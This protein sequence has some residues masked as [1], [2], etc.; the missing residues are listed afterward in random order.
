M[1]G[2][3]ALRNDHAL[4]ETCKPIVATLPVPSPFT[5][6]DM[7][8][9]FGLQREQAR[10]IEL[11][12]ARLGGTA[13]CGLYVVTDDVDYVVH[14]TDTSPFHSLHIVMHEVGHWLLG[15][16]DAALA[17]EAAPA[18]ACA[19][20]QPADPDLG[21]AATTLPEPAKLVTLLRQA[22]PGLSPSKVRGVLGRTVYTAGQERGAE[23]FATLATSHVAEQLRRR[24]LQS[25]QH[26]LPGL[27]TAFD[28]P[29]RP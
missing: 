16:L 12:P 11:I 23:V 22:I 24:R 19:S 5:V 1:T 10:P 20:A 18:S 28:S 14:A 27:I 7:L 15:H 4:V 6:A 26:T 25:R 3:A 9:E 8:A 17:D 29:D 2:A 13:P 21:T